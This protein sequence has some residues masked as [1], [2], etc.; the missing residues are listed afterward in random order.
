MCNHVEEFFAS[1]YSYVWFPLN[2]LKYIKVKRVFNHVE[3]A[4]RLSKLVDFEAK[5]DAH[6]KSTP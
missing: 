2:P 3:T 1:L 5:G 4:V 6:T